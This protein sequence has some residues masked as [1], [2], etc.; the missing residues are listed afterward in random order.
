MVKYKLGVEKMK[1]YGQF[2][3]M[4]GDKVVDACLSF[5]RY[6]VA[7]HLKLVPCTEGEY[8]WYMVTRKSDN[9]V[10]PKNLSEREVY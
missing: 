4:D 5:F 1:K 2:F 8:A 3:V 6:S 10:I 9:P 7:P